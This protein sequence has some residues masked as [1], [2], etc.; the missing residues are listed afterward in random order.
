LEELP[1]AIQDISWKAQV[2]LC[3]RFRPLTA[4]G[5][6]AN[7]VVVAIA[8]EMAAFVWAVAREVQSAR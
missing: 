7:Q 6:H 8:R 3:T 1:Q 5:K 4:R 2:R